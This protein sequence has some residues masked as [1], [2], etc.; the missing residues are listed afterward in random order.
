MS[1]ENQVEC[2]KLKYPYPL[3]PK[4]KP[5]EKAPGIPVKL[6]SNLFKVSIKQ[7]LPIYEYC[8]EVN[9]VDTSDGPGD[10]PGVAKK[11]RKLPSDI[12]RQILD[13]AL[14]G[15]IENNKPKLNPKSQFNYVSD[16]KVS[17]LYTL[18]E[19]IGP[20][21]NIKIEL[22]FTEDYIEG[23]KLTKKTSKFVVGLSKG[24]KLNISNC[25]QIC[26]TGQTTTAEAK[27]ILR[28]VNT[29]VS[30]HI[31]TLPR[32]VLTNTS[33]FPQDNNYQFE[34][35]RTTIANHG[36]FLSARYIESGLSLN[37]AN[38]LATFLKDLNLKD[39]LVQTFG[40]N[41]LNGPLNPRQID[42]LK[43]ELKNKQITARHHNYGSNNPHYRKYRI[44]DVGL[45]AMHKF[46]YVPLGGTKPQELTIK[47]Y[48]KKEYNYTIKF[49]NLPCI[50]DSKARKIPFEVCHLVEGQRI[51]RKNTP[52]ETQKIITQSAVPAD[53]HF[54]RVFDNAQLM[55]KYSS[56]MNSFGLEF[57]LDSI[58]VEGRELSAMSL[59]GGGNGSLLPRDG[60]YDAMRTRFLNP[61]KI[62]RWAIAF[63]G[64]DRMAREKNNFKWEEFAKRYVHEGKLKGLEINPK[65]AQRYI[66]VQ[67]DKQ[68]L[69]KQLKEFFKFMN[70]NSCDHCIFILPVR[71]IDWLYPYL[72]YLE[73]FT[74]SPG[75]KST[76]VSC[77]K[78]DNYMRKVVGDPRGGG[79]FLSNLLLKYNTKLGGVNFAINPDP[80]RRYLD[81]NWLYISVD[82]CHPAPNDRLLQSV[83]GVVGM[84][85]ITSR[86][87]SYCTRISVQRKCNEKQSSTIEEVLD[88]GK[89]VQEVVKSYMARKN[90]LPTSI[91]I[92]RDGVSDGQLDVVIE[93]ELDQ[94]LGKLNQL[95]ER[96]PKLTCLVVQKRHK[97]RFMREQ[98]V[99]DRRGN[100]D[101]NIK[102][103]TVVD[104][105]VVHP[106]HHT[107]Y[108]AAHKAIKGTSRPAHIYFRYDENNFGLDEAQQ[109]IL[110]LSHLSPRCTKSTSIPTPVNLADLAAERGKN[111]VVSWNDDNP[112]VPASK[113][114][115]ELNKFLAQVGDANYLNSLFYI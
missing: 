102:P 78:F 24:S 113:R 40:Q 74:K 89:L 85:N 86:N 45:S 84:W 44:Q 2:L 99:Q 81:E 79:M 100:N 98:P 23:K 56:P 66:D 29:I 11:T 77:I 105:T 53:K 54:K 82:V 21:R 69:T 46:Q 57:P 60:G 55:K 97:Q 111:I 27:A 94:V 106:T 71:D 34:A 72:Q 12:R 39:L 1:K 67:V 101:Y 88:L 7:N 80:K 43:K 63:L 33:I 51:T 58:R 36:I 90:K 73:A 110:T 91:I 93:R 42:E 75:K 20:T 52:S 65:P 3:R 15:W 83:V 17:I 48:F 107:F 41:A 19:I 22:D 37:I 14:R 50:I 31:V 76:R 16:V 4:R 8:V 28:A 109:M 47:D 18:F 92:M 30:G 26:K 35:D 5:G 64:D 38:T 62:N 108:L 112:N 6:I 104:N 114:I 25:M 115:D 9:A 70:D 95:K 32:F 103:G 49:P 10:E 68:T 13:Q 87:M 61:V 96:K 59:I